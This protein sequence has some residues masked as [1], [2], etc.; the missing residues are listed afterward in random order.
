MVIADGGTTGKVYKTMQLGVFDDAGTPID[1]QWVTADF[2]GADSSVFLPKIL[3]GIWA[4]A[5]PVQNSSMTI[6]YQ[7]GKSTG[8]VDTTFSLDNGQP[9]AST[10]FPIGSSIYPTDRAETGNLNKWIPLDVGYQ[11]GKYLR[12]KFSNSLNPNFWR[13]NSYLFLVSL[14]PMTIP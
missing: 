7:V 4:D 11:A 12:F 1:A 9:L 6:S 2:G 13:L 14:Q 5:L 3:N 10:L 8:Y